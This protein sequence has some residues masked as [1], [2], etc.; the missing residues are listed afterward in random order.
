MS[1]HNIFF[2]GE[3]RKIS[4]LFWIEKR[5]LTSAMLEIGIRKASSYG[6][7]KGGCLRQCLLRIN[8]K[9]SNLDHFSFDSAKEE[10]YYK[11]FSV[12]NFTQF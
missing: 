3:M 6:K 10:N 9:T 8:Y 11:M 1:T 5:A 7:P 2:H 12:E 4:I